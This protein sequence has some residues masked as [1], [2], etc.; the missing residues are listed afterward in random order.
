MSWE[1]LR[2]LGTAQLHEV[3]VAAGTAFVV[4]VGAAIV[5]ALGWQR[6]DRVMLLLGQ[7]DQLGKLRI[8]KAAGGHYRL[9]QMTKGSGSLR[10][11]RRR[12]PGMSAETRP[13][14]SVQHKVVEGGL[15]I[16]LPPWACAG[17]AAPQ[18][19][20]IAPQPRPSP[21]RSTP[22][23]LPPPRAAAPPTT[24]ETEEAAQRA[25]RLVHAIS[26]FY[27]RGFAP[28]YADLARASG[29]PQ[30][31]IG[32]LLHRLAKDAR[33]IRD[34]GGVRPRGRPP[35]GKVRA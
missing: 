15:E 1:E 7:A 29:I 31:S 11:Q 28:S 13:S 12:L 9:Q 32:E 30:G 24:L 17:D 35:L 14:Q 26:E 2:P 22:M 16:E 4:S 10:V 19:P 6:Q 18:R 33:I 21:P 34:D 27:Q 5:T 25:D 23:A 20:A 8:V 3:R